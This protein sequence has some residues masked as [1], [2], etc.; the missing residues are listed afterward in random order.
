MEGTRQFPILAMEQGECKRLSVRICQ[1]E[2]TVENSDVL[3]FGG[4]T[5]EAGVGDHC[6]AKP[7]AVS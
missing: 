2:A 4:P 5:G 7:S 3:L 1:D 6:T